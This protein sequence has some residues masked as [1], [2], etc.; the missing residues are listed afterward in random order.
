MTGQ[1][2]KCII[3]IYNYNVLFIHLQLKCIRYQVLK[4]YIIEIAI[5]YIFEYLKHISWCKLRNV[6]IG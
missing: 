2:Q 1:I 6:F 3:F 4:C 5:I